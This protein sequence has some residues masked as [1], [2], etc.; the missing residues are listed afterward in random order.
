MARCKHSNKYIWLGHLTSE[1]KSFFIIRKNTEQK[2]GLA[3]DA[4]KHGAGWLMPKG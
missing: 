3:P 1:S 2:I 4:R